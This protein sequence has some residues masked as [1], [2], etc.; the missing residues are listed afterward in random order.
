MLY[1]KVV[2][3]CKDRGLSIGK[4]E[5]E[6]GFSN[7]SLNKWNE[8]EPGVWKVKKLA[9]YFGVSVEYF[10]EAEEGEEERV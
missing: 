6:L 4:L 7:G 1:D 8:S 3:L 5:K 9:D 2:A 10:L